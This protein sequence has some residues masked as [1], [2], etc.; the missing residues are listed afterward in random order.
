MARTNEVKNNGAALETSEKE[1]LKNN[2]DLRQIRRE[3]AIA[4]QKEADRKFISAASLHGYQVSQLEPHKNE[5]FLKNMLGYVRKDYEQAQTV[6]KHLEGEIDTAIQA[7]I[8]SPNDKTFLLSRLILTGDH[9]LTEKAGE[10]EKVLHEKFG[11]MKNDV[12]AYQK[13]LEDPL[14]R[15]AKL[16]KVPSMEAWM[17]KDAKTRRKEV[18]EWQKKL[19]EAQKKAAKNE[20]ET[21]PQ[22]L[23]KYTDLLEG[24]RAQKIIGQTTIQKFLDGFKKVDAKEKERWINEFPKEMQRYEALWKDIRGTLQGKTL[25]AMESRR[26]AMGYGEL[27]MAFEQAKEHEGHRLAFVYRQKLV[28]ARDVEKIIGDHTYE[29]FMQ[30]PDG[31]LS[32]PLQARYQYLDQFDSQMTRYRRLWGEI[33]TLSEKDRDVFERNRH[34][35]GYT[36]LK[37]AWEAKR[38]GAPI[39]DPSVSEAEQALK[40]IENKSVREGI[41]KAA[42]LVAEGGHEKSGTFLK[43]LRNVFGRTRASE[44]SETFAQKIGRARRQ[45]QL[46]DASQNDSGTF[47]NVQLKNKAGETSRVAQ[48]TVNRRDAL[49]DFQLKMA[50]HALRGEAMGGHDDLALSVRTADEKTISLGGREVLSLQKAIEA[51]RRQKQEIA[52]DQAA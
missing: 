19:E 16:L 29:A 27:R 10:I 51:R 18:G 28:V 6:L 36:E 22:E 21:S 30:A 43:N 39:Q 26:D 49:R 46:E 35:W 7:R 42:D 34:A 47:Q 33:R 20:A 12:K 41:K 14:V 15:D 52:L 44:Q 9:N 5:S 37:N 2:N 50:D 1:A 17:Q 31:L 13:I 40:Q 45:N 25:N 3:I 23:K 48:V 38:A 32:Q 8:A 4:A 11:R 24:A